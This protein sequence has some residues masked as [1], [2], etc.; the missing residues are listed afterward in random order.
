MFTCVLEANISNSNIKSDDL[1]WYRLIK[2]TST[3]EGVNQSS[4]IHFTTSTINSTWTINL[5]ISNAI[6]SYTG[7]Y[8]VRLPPDDDV[9]NVSVT[10]ATSML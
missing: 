9:C 5:T 7:Y 3:E 1:R 6:T 2:D 8:W 4:N 10:V